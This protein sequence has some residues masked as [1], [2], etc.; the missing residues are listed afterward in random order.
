[1]RSPSV[2]VRISVTRSRARSTARACTITAL[3]ALATAPAMGACARPDPITVELP[4]PSA[5]GPRPDLFPTASVATPAPAPTA[6]EPAKPT[7]FPL[8]QLQTNA[9]SLGGPCGASTRAFCGTSGRVAVTAHQFQFR[10]PEQP[11][12]QPVSLGR[13][14]VAAAHVTS[15]CV[16]GDHLFV[17]TS[18]IIC[19]SPSGTSIEGLV[20]DMTPGQLAFVQKQAGLDGPPLLSAQEWDLA[21]RSAHSNSLKE[22]H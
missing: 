4:R 20:S 1:M 16:E 22:K 10:G 5:S 14:D 15:A 6:T 11:A 2:V 17:T 12:C 21:I 13:P 3:G 8:T 18:C 9:P 7:P 19:R